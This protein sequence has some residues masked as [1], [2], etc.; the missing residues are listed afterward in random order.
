MTTLKFGFWFGT[1]TISWNL[2]IR[3]CLGNFDCL[4]WELQRVVTLN[5]VQLM[6]KHLSRILS[7]ICLGFVQDF[8]KILRRSLRDFWRKELRIDYVPCIPDICHFF[9]HG[10][11]FWRIKFTPKKRVNYDKIHR[12]LPIFCVITAKYTVNCQFFALNL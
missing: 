11:N 2:V 12:K 8:A 5:W 9:L 3:D 7:R 4:A 6:T 10:Q 1:G